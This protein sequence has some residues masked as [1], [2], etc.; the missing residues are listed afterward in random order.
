M[1]LTGLHFLLS[2]QCSNECDHCFAW[3]SPRQRGTMTWEQIQGLLEE[4]GAMGSVE[5]VYFEGGEPF[6]FHPILVKAVRLAKEMGF[7][8]GA[9]SNAYWASTLEDAKIWLSPMA[10][11]LADLSIS[12][13]H[14]HLAAKDRHRIT[15]AEKA[16]RLLKIPLAT[17]SIANPEEAEGRKGML[18]E[19]ESAV[20]YRGRA[21]E[22]LAP[23]A[24]K[25]T[26]RKF[27]HCPHE[28]LNDPG[29]LHVDALGNLHVCQ[30]LIVGNVTDRSLAEV[31]EN[32]RPA[33]DPILGLLISGGPAELAKNLEYDVKEEYADACHLCYETRRANQDR[34]P[35]T[36][37]PPAMYG[38]MSWD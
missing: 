13:D 28:N 25:H 31:C 24:P 8:V 29:R 2:Y 3:G 22:T 27:T 38:D 6:L 16:A 7:T 35:Q 10:G 36:L 30:G 33:E 26:W 23:A 9:V 17:I 21:V 15:H 11:A 20:M 18:P 19:G 4:A 34:Y 37:A 32:Y 12:N 1:K 14:F 5:S